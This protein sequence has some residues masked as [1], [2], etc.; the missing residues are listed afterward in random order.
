MN[1][2]NVSLFV[3][4]AGSHRTNSWYAP[5]QA[6]VPAFLYEPNASIMKA[7]CFEEVGNRYGI[8]QLSDNSHLFV[9]ADEIAEFPGR[10]FQIQSISS[11]NKQEL[12]A[13]LKDVLQANIAV[14]NFP[15]SAEQLRKK[16]KL[17]DG[18]DVYIFATTLAD[19]QHRL[20]ICRKIG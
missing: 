14:R 17:R 13:A 1:D 8:H 5:Y 9:S 19:G 2:D 18:G 7:G 6:V 10:R 20:Y 15:L 4:I 16:L 11:M 12:K 3:P